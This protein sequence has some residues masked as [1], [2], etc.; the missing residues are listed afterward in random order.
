ME[1]NTANGLVKWA[2]KEV[3]K[4][5]KRGPPTNLGIKILKLK[6]QICQM[7]CLNIMHGKPNHDTVFIKMALEQQ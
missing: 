5:R 2:E 6:C 1:G 4:P 3:T 7:L